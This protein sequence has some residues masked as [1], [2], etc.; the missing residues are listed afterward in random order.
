MNLGRDYQMAGLGQVVLVVWCLFLRQ[1]PALP[2]HTPAKS[3]DS[4]DSAELAA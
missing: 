2:G 1:L 4:L 3:R